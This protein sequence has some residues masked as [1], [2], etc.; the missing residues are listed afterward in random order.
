MR[1]FAGLRGG[2]NEKNEGAA[3][4]LFL[5]PAR[6]ARAHAQQTPSLHV[7]PATSHT[8]SATDVPFVLMRSCT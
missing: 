3:K 4:R 6:L 5:P 1:R 7:R 8:Q 2:R